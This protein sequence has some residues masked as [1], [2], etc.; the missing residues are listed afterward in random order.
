M[1]AGELT[2]PARPEQVSSDW[3]TDVLRDSGSLNEARITGIEREAISA[4]VGFLGQLVRLT[5]RYDRRESGAPASLIGK[6]PIDQEWGR[7]IAAFYGFYR[8][9]VGFYRELAPRISLRTPRCYFSAINDEATEFALLMEDMSTTGRVGDQVGGCKFT[10]AELAFKHLAVLHASW[11]NRDELSELSWLPTLVELA[12]AA[13][14][15]A[16]PQGWR[17]FVEA[18]GHVLPA[19]VREA[20]PDLNERV[21]KLVDEFEGGPMTLVHGDWRLD[22]F[23]FGNAG[24]GY[25]LAVVDW[26]VTNRGYPT[27]DLAWFLGGNLEPEQRRQ[28]EGELIRLY[29]RTLAEKGVAD[30]SFDECWQDY[31]RNLL[32]IL[33]G[34]I[35]A[36]F[37]TFD[38]TNERGV[39]PFELLLR[40]Y[41]AAVSD[42]HAMELL[43]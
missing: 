36:N 2:F 43:D 41:S 6:F 19:D 28:W 24:A 1:V 32:A 26:Q 16:Y 5:L 40:R 29:Q 30:Y 38:P 3:L 4:G 33:A 20:A 37:A 11:W 25:G 23:F 42:L 22:N 14:S 10:Q 18:Y 9:E 8:T 34:S 17:P 12:R 7:Q 39:A 15:Q 31:R 13:L 27:Y 35:M 21:L